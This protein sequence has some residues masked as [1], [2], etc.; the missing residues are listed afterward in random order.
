MSLILDAIKKSERERQQQQVPD[1]N[2]NHNDYQ[3]PPENLNRVW[4]IVM[5]L[6]VAS[7]FMIYWWVK[8]ESKKPEVLK[9]AV[10]E[11][12]ADIKSK[13]SELNNLSPTTRLKTGEKINNLKP[14]QTIQSL[15]S[16]NKKSPKHHKRNTKLMFPA[17]NR[18]TINKDASSQHTRVA[19]PSDNKNRGDRNIVTL[20]LLP[21]SILNKL[22]D[23]IY[24]S[25]VYTGDGSTSFVVINK[26]ITGEGEKISDSITVEQINELNIVINIDGQKVRLEKLKSWHRR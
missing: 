25:H 17:T 11:S 26:K 15:R 22:P 7:V 8:K 16:E 1:L 5:L 19:P 6:L 9:P 4:I 10:T 2:A 12:A 14:K 3:Q 24:S 13:P 20:E 18:G 21:T 23:L